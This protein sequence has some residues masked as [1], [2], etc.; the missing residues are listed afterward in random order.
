MHWELWA[1]NSGNLIC[2]Y[3]TEA[4]ALAMVRALVDDGWSA[5]D[6]GLGLEFDDDDEGDDASLPPVL[7]GV[8][9]TQRA[10]DGQA[11][12]ERRPGAA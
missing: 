9:L 3:E 8:A 1:L 2:E 7:S 6:L 11:R 5:D 12:R 10:Y 4:D